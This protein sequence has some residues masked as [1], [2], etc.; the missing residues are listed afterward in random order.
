M[1]NDLGLE[2]PDNEEVG[3][4][5]AFSM[6]FDEGQCDG[7]GRTRSLDVACESCDAPADAEHGPLRARRAVV[8]PLLEELRSELPAGVARALEIT[9]W[10][11]LHDQ[12]L[13][14]FLDALNHL[15]GTG[16]IGRVQAACGVL[17]RLLADAATSPRYRPD[18]AGWRALDSGLE[19][20]HGLAVGCLQA[21]RAA[22]TADAERLAGVA[23]G[24][25]TEA[26]GGVGTWAEQRAVWFGPDD[27]PDNDLVWAGA[28]RALRQLGA[29]HGHIIAV[30]ESGQHLFERVTG[31]AACPPGFG[32]ALRMAE[33]NADV[34]LDPDRFWRSTGLAYR[35][36]ASTKSNGRAAIGTVAESAEWAGDMLRVQEQLAEA[37]RDLPDLAAADE[38]RLARAVVR[39]GH[40]IAERAAKYLIATVLAAYRGRDYSVLRKMGVSAL[41]S[42][43]R[44]VNLD[45]LLLG[46]DGA[47]RHGDAHGEFVV[48][49]DGVRFTADRREYDF[50]TWPELV[51]RLFAGIESTSALLTAVLCAVAGTAVGDDIVDLE[52]F[53]G[54]HRQIRLAAA[55]DGWTHLHIGDDQSDLVVTGA[56][57][58][59]LTLAA[60]GMIA[61]YATADAVS[62]TVDVDSPEGRVVFSGPLEPVRAFRSQAAGPDSEAWFL[63]VCRT[64]T[65][66]GGRIADDTAVRKVVAVNVMRAAVSE[67]TPIGERSLLL[68][69]W[70]EAAKRARDR[71]LASAVTDVA[72]G[73]RLISNGTRPERTYMRAVSKLTSY[74]SEEV[75]WPLSA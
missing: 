6:S 36:L 49:A 69:P 48:E 68:A 73:L 60:V 43:A 9:E 74:G 23:Q 61:T 21:L 11:D 52:A 32:L 57:P 41:L 58:Q 35:R 18:L 67:S 29:E 62:L 8:D 24:Q 42:E 66:N 10:V 55:A 13:V 37:I 1:T 26:Q 72:W 20:M 31:E 46:I 22:T 38:T 70:L 63:D 5:S 16:D 27:D 15:V 14:V 34:V 59:T 4:R 2:V 65:V 12:W 30:E 53:F 25:L 33:V 75:D 45:S 19:G 47:M 7:C 51:D 3:L 56:R 50:L 40:L 64:W 28:L 17:R 39:L 44:D 71:E 54:S